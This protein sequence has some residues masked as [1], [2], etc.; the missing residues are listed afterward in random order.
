M[1]TP[2]VPPVLPPRC[3]KCGGRWGKSWDD[4]PSCL[5]CGKRWYGPPR[6]IQA[7][8]CPLCGQHNRWTG[9]PHCQSCDMSEQ[10]F[11]RASRRAALTA[12]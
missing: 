8:V 11:Y 6:Q 9:N 10:R 4:D 7:G 1:D 12:T 3:P 2:V 5:S